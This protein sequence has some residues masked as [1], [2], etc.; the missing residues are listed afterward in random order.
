MFLRSRVLFNDLSIIY[1][2]IIYLYTY[3]LSA[4][5]THKIQRA[6]NFWISW[7]SI[8]FSH[9]SI[10]PVKK[11]SACDVSSPY[12]FGVGVGRQLFQAYVFSHNQSLLYLVLVPSIN[13]HVLIY[14]IYNYSFLLDWIISVYLVIMLRSFQLYDVII[15]KHKSRLLY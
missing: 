5:T 4:K 15:G 2:A 6:G 1:P 8:W 12:L 14:K 9:L 7:E 11:T 3:R 10:L 13:L